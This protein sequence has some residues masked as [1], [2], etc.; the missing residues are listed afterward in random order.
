MKKYTLIDKSW[1]GYNASGQRRELFLG[2]EFAPSG[3]VWTCQCGGKEF[4]G[5]SYRT[6]T[7]RF[8]REWRG[9]NIPVGVEPVRDGWFVVDLLISLPMGAGKELWAP[10][11][12][13]HDMP[14]RKN[15][16][17]ETVAYNAVVRPALEAAIAAMGLHT[18]VEELLRK[19]LLA[20]SGLE[21]GRY[22]VWAPS[23]VSREFPGEMYRLEEVPVDPVVDGQFDALRAIPKLVF[24]VED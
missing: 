20:G 10:P 1:S 18:I 16:Q 11:P 7:S 3:W 8:P 13:D 12:T 23:A 2:S 4:A 6:V 5:D 14:F 21:P 19:R 22:A 24:R 17:A 9:E 15:W